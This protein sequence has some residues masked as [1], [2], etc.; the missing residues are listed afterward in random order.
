MF[1]EGSFNEFSTRLL[2]ILMG[3][4][5]CTEFDVRTIAFFHFSL[6]VSDP[7]KDEDCFWLH[8]PN[9]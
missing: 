8:L 6:T 2:A 7:V 1:C 9:A 4:S 3:V 5:G